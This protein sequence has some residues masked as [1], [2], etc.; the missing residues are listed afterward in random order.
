[1][2]HPRRSD[3]TDADGQILVLFAAA[4]IVLLALGALLF[5]GAQALVVRRQLQNGGDAAALAAA[6]IMQVNAT[7]CTAARVS[8]T[9]TDG[10]NDLYLAAKASVMANLGWTAAQVASRMT[11]SCAT[12]SAYAGLAVTV[13]L[14][15][16][17]PAFFGQGS[18][19]VTTSS[20]GMNGQVANGDFSV[21]TLD[22][23]HT[24]WPANRRG[25]PSFLINGGIT[26]TF[27]GSIM[28]DSI[29][30]RSDNTNAAMKAMNSAFTMTLLNDATIRVAGEVASGTATHVTPAPVE[31]ARPILPDPLSGLTK[32]CNAVDAATNCLGTNGSLPT[33]NMASTGSGICKNQNPCI[34]T[35]GTYTGG[36]VAGGGSNASTVLMRPGVYFIR[37]GGLTIKSGSGRIFAIPWGT[38]TQGYT[39]ATAKTDYAL[40]KTD[41]QVEQQFQTNCPTP[42]TANPIP[43]SCGVLIYNAPSSASSSWNTNNDPISVGAQG[44][45]MVRAYQPS[46]DTITTNRTLFASY[47]NLVFWQA[48]TPA[49]SGSGQT[50]P[51][52]SMTGGGCIVLSGTGYAAGGPVDFGGGSCGSGG[53]DISLKLQF[54]C[55][56]L[57]L[58][59]N[60]NFYFA[61][62]KD[63]FATPTTYGLVK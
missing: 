50:Q 28:V 32:P 26:A 60:N 40:A 9:A 45:F 3:R 48:R 6:N 15:G 36:I 13:R 14:T 34:I 53:G 62:S 23:S 1:M 21:S 29:C 58:S 51:T 25:C 11:V 12:D 44:L 4:M 47:K 17:G 18:I 35:P 42:T 19:P 57:T 20:T 63:W 59:G 38:S 8:A 37:G 61:Y 49:P 5:S 22:P 2:Q 33:V 55:W 52:I 27:E 7:T 16:T 46:W 56:D 39:D 31:H 10:T 30:L 41:V 43:S 24:S 54:I